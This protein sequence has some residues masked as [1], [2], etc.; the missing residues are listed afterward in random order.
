MQ[1][2]HTPRVSLQTCPILTQLI[3]PA[4][5]TPR[6]AIGY[7]SG[8]GVSP[9][10]PQDQ[11]IARPATDR[12]RRTAE[13]QPS[14]CSRQTT[15]QRKLKSARLVSSLDSPHTIATIH[16]HIH[17]RPPLP[18]TWRPSCSRRRVRD[19][20]H[21]GGTLTCCSTRCSRESYWTC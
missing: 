1:R 16:T 15:A 5:A 14:Q 20:S 12:G 13:K 18:Q 9:V 4:A 19:A 11:T 6:E 2:T 3:I 17:T 21:A 7:V 8:A 10:W